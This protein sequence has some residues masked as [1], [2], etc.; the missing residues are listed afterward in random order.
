[1][2][3][4]AARVAQVRARVAAAG[5]D[6]SA[7]TVVAVTKGQGPSAVAAAW[8][9]G[10]RDFGESYAQ[11]LAGKQLV[12]PHGGR[13]HFVGAVQRRKVAKLAPVVHLWQS[14]D[15]VSLGDEI[16]RRAP[17]ARVLVQVNVAADPRRNGCAWGE[18]PALVE[19]LRRRAL[20]VQ[21]L[22]CIG[23]RPDPRPQ[24]RRLA[25]LAGELGLAEVSM[26]MSDDLEAA[27][28]EGSTMDRLGTALFGPRPERPHLR[29]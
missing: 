6:W 8:E 25:A 12:L 3:G 19:E 16:G 14:L 28:Q 20:D 22:M 29:R 27:V 2:E 18:A 15:R 1:M 23:P 9:A 21:G 17:G 7:L 4:V 5:G 26:G 24:F 10:L 13:W 11:E